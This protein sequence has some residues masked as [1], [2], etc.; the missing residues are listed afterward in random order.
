M[1]T[2][3]KI[4]G[5]ITVGLF[6]FQVSTAQISTTKHNFSALGWTNTNNGIC[7]PCHTPHQAILPVVVGPLW[8]HES[9]TEAFTAYPSGGTIDATDLGAPDEGALACLGCHD[10][11]T[12][13]DNFVPQLGTSTTF[14]AAS[15]SGY[16]GLDLTN[17]HPVSFTY[18]DALAVA[19]AGLHHPLTAAG[20]T[21]LGGK[22]DGDYLFSNKVQCASCHDVHSTTYPKFLRANNAASQMCLDCHNK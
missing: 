1:K 8:A 17:D 2:I 15:V 21:S 18:D 14:M 5:M 20:N 3:G 13:L 6:I 12:G 10:G 9:S 16:V 22:I 11:T 19:D 7:G 4:I